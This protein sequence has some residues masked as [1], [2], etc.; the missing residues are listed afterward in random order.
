MFGIV[1]ESLLNVGKYDMLTAGH[2]DTKIIEVM[3]ELL[4]LP[5]I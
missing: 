1:L 4:D 2:M 3:T 5:E